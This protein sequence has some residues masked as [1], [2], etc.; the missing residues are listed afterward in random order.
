MSHRPNLFQ[1]RQSM[2]LGLL[3]LG[4]LAL[5]LTATAHAAPQVQPFIAIELSTD[6]LDLGNAPVPGDYDS[7][8]T[9]TLT[10]GANVKHGGVVA[11]LT[12]LEHE[13]SNAVIE[14]SRVFVK[15]LFTQAFIPFNGP[16][17]VLGP[18]SPGVFQ[19]ELSFRVKTQWS[20]PPGTYTGTLTL[21]Y[22][23]AP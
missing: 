19:A 17:H 1:P 16:V 7:P 6:H 13:A 14:P 20:D 22:G 21:T 11:T 15:T 9:L 5:L 18:M 3:A 23:L 2:W 8:N 12:P 4:G 10:I